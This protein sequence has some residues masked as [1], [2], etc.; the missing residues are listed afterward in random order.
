MIDDPVVVNLR[1]LVLMPDEMY[2]YQATHFRSIDPRPS[3]DPRRASRVSI[4][5]RNG[6]S[7]SLP[8]SPSAKGVVVTLVPYNYPILLMMNPSASITT[9]V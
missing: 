5:L 1:R 3:C 7:Q 4:M 8:P 2:T 9:R 6:P